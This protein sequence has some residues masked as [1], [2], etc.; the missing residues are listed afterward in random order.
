MYREEDLVVVAI[1]AVV[2]GVALSGST[3]ADPGRVV[4]NLFNA[5][6]ARD[7]TSFTSLFSQDAILIPQYGMNPVQG[8]SNILSLC[9]ELFN[10]SS[11]STANYSS[12]VVS[13]NNAVVQ[14]EGTRYNLYKQYVRDAGIELFVVDP[15][16]D[17]ITLVVNF[18][19]TKQDNATQTRSQMQKVWSAIGATNCAAF[20]SLFADDGTWMQYSS[21]LQVPLFATGRQQIESL[22]NRAVIGVAEVLF[23]PSATAV[24]SNGAMA[25]TN[26][27]IVNKATFLPPLLVWEYHEFIFDSQ[28]QL[29]NLTVY[30]MLPR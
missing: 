26:V 29:Q 14:W 28:F 13:M 6:G 12:L 16:T 19:D 9:Y 1:V 3:A 7:C 22:C 4:D 18:E 20:S 23:I 8:R 10:Y 27:A 2:V 17:L 11:V 25:F 30:A 15:D 24:S 5:L 21:G